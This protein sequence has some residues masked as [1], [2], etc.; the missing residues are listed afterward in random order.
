MRFLDP[1]FDFLSVL[2]F[3]CRFRGFQRSRLDP[4]HLLYDSDFAYHPGDR[5]C[6]AGDHHLTPRPAGKLHQASSYRPLDLSDMDVCFRDRRNRLLDALLA[7]PI[8]LIA[9]LAA[10]V[11]RA[12]SAVQMSDIT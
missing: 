12:E 6:A 11:F 9:D 3:S 5:G 8:A 4:A 1:V 7:G 2:P 10:V